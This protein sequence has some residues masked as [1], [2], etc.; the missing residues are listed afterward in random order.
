MDWKANVEKV[1][2]DVAITET[3]KLSGSAKAGVKV[4]SIVDLGGNAS[5]SFEKGSVNKVKFSV[6]LLLP[7]SARHPKPKEADPSAPAE[8]TENQ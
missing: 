6:P 2:F 4:V 7:A 5:K 1:G 3:D 8:A